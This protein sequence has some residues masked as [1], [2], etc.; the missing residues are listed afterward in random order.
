M[1]SLL[2]QARLQRDNHAS[3]VSGVWSINAEAFC[4]KT[5]IPNLYNNAVDYQYERESDDVERYSSELE[6][7]LTK[8]LGSLTIEQ[9][10]K[11]Q[12]QAS[13]ACMNDDGYSSY[14]WDFVTKALESR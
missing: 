11:I 13:D 2:E 7:S 3:Q 10:E 5:G 4:K 12:A 8:Q 6:G 14:F 9:I 1:T